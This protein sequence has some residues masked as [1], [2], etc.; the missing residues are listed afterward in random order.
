M[1]IQQRQ[2]VDEAWCHMLFSGLITMFVFDI[3]QTHGGCIQI[4]S[5]CTEAT[6]TVMATGLPAAIQPPL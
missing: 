6:Y 3:F 2:H 5:G 1:A 4:C